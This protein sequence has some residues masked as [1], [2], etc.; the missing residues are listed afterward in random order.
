MG[1]KKND[2]SLPFLFLTPCTGRTCRAVIPSE[3]PQGAS[4]G[5][6]LTAGCGHWAEVGAA[7][8]AAPSLAHGGHSLGITSI[9]E[10]TSKAGPS[11]RA[12]RALARDD[13]LAPLLSTERKERTPS[14]PS[15]AQGGATSKA[16]PSLAHYVRS[17]G[18][19]STRPSC[20]K[21]KKR[22]EGQTS[23]FIL[24]L[25]KRRVAVIP[26]ERT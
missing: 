23:L 5:P 22:R 6:A 2:G 16:D 15:P 18:M 12:L 3:R 1:G 11:L 14:I 10:C 24:L 9:V 4:E 19:T 21:G 20:E 13:T 26:S 8:G 25:T 17:L 7:R